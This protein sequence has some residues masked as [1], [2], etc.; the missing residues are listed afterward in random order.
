MFTLRISIRVC[1]SISFLSTGIRNV[2]EVRKW[3]MIRK[4]SDTVCIVN[5]QGPACRGCC[6]AQMLGHSCSLSVL[7][8]LTRLGPVRGNRQCYH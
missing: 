3:S 5:I 7:L 1:E 6:C 4:L 2:T 8:L